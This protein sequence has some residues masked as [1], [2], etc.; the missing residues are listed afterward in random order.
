MET[1][2]LIAT[3]NFCNCICVTVRYFCFHAMFLQVSSQQGDENVIL[4]IPNYSTLL[5]YSL[6]HHEHAVLC[7]IMTS[8]VRRKKQMGNASNFSQIDSFLT[9]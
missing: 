3:L 6:F 5:E 7:Y 8:Q 9:L 1:I 4:C 2:I